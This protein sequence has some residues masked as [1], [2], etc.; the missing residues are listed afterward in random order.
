MKRCAAHARFEGYVGLLLPGSL[1]VLVEMRSHPAWPADV[2]SGFRISRQPD[3]VGRPPRRRKNVAPTTGRHSQFRRPNISLGR[4]APGGA[5]GCDRISSRIGRVGARPKTRNIASPRRS[6]K[7]RSDRLRS[8]VLRCSLKWGRAPRAPLIPGP[9]SISRRDRRWPSAPPPSP[10]KR[11]PSHEAARNVPTFK[12]PSRPRTLGKHPRMR[13]HTRAYWASRRA[14]GNPQSCFAPTWFR[15][16]VGLPL[17]GHL[18]I[19]VQIRS[20][21]ARTVDSGAGRHTSWQPEVARRPPAPSRT[22]LPAHGTPHAVSRFKHVFSPPP[23]R[24]ELS[25]ATA[26]RNVWDWWSHAPK[27]ATVLHPRVAPMVGRTAATRTSRGT[28]PNKVARRGH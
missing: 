14:S 15:G 2:A 17:L 19:L 5:P 28:R 16:L 7:G 24:G 18:A 9:A 23:P 8:D 11:P 26:Y 27:P 20:H 6:S 10:R 4:V 21:S 3:V 25:D 1:T 12:S 22:R 13:L